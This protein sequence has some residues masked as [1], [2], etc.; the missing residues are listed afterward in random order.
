MIRILFQ[1]LLYV[2]GSG[3]IVLFIFALS[4][5]SDSKFIPMKY[6][7]DYDRSRSMINIFLASF[8]LS[9]IFNDRVIYQ[10]HIQSGGR[11]IETITPIQIGNSNTSTITIMTGTVWAMINSSN[12]QNDEYIYIVIISYQNEY[13]IK[14]IITISD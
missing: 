9:V 12:K 3:F 7:S 2:S 6:K 14:S 4:V 13:G 1:F 8:V 11:S 10:W 5:L